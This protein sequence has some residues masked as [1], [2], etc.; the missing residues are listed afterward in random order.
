MSMSLFGNYLKEMGPIGGAIKVEYSD[1]VTEYVGALEWNAVRSILCPQAT[2]LGVSFYEPL[3]YSIKKI[4][5]FK[6]II[7]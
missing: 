6:R 3:F 2:C 4:S 5:D 1:G 7:V